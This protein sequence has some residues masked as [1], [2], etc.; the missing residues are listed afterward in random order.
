MD[1]YVSPIDEVGELRGVVRDAALLDDHLVRW[2]RQ[3]RC[4]GLRMDAAVGLRS[5]GI[6]RSHPG[7][8]L[9]DE[10]LILATARHRGSPVTV[11]NRPCPYIS[12][13][14]TTSPFRR[15]FFLDPPLRAV[16]STMMWTPVPEGEAST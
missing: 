8:E 10:V 1:V 7:G 6:R 3:S 9:V 12:I 11:K 14:P 15:T 5:P 2:P 16:P 13:S 4:L